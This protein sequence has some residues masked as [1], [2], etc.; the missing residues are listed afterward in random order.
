MPEQSSIGTIRA[1]VEVLLPPTGDFPGAVALEVDRHV[2]ELIELALP[3]FTDLIATL[4]DA[5][6]AEA[7]PGASFAGLDHAGRGRVMR[8]MSEDPSPDVR[9][10]VDAVIVF[11]FGGTYSEWTGFDRETRTLE[12]P[13]VWADVG[14]HGPVVA[15]PDFRDGM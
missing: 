14:Y 2:V 11:A 15:H 13:A 4:F 1:A 9:D 10:A 7:S 6:A 12:P 8:T 5:Y 3:G